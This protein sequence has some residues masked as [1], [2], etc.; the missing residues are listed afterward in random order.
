MSR[1]TR[2]TILRCTSALITAGLAATALTAVAAAPAQAASTKGG[3][4]TRSEVMARA[5]YWVDQGVPYNQGGWHTDGQGTNYRED[6][7]GYVSMAWHATESFTTWSLPSVSSDISNSSLLPGDALNYSDAH[8]ILFGGWQDKAAGTFTYFA[9]QNPSVLTNKYTG[10][11]NSSSVAG[12]PT[13]V[14]Q[15]IRYDNIVE[16]APAPVY[17]QTAAA[18]FTGDGA[19][20]IIAKDASGNLKMWVHNPAGT[21]NSPAQV[22]TGW[23]FTQT[24]AA[25]FNNDGKAD[26]IARDGS[27]NLKYWKGNG[28]ATFQSPTTLTAGWDF[29]QTAAADFDGDGNVDLI[30]KDSANNLKIW[31]GNGNGTFA[32]PGTQ[33]AGWNFT[34]TAAADFTGDGKADI[35]AKDTNGKL[36]MWVHNSGGS[37]NAPVELTDWNYSQ[38]TAAD[39]DGNGKVDLI[40][41]ND[42]SADLNIWAGNG[43][44]TF[45]TPYKL[46]GGW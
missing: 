12:W 14:Y 44:G 45:T 20:D 10:N 46:T 16:D 17:T 19:A 38:T 22:T 43:N 23:N 40:A 31:A 36:K 15:A 6:C 33:S 5:Q 1:T 24:A 2:L 8:V 25:D 7:S 28:D 13:S 35:I 37:F 4:I 30:A 26:I 9:E 29:T 3:K 39:F 21:F 11:L 18:D 32:A 41:R 27:G 42:T 34:Q